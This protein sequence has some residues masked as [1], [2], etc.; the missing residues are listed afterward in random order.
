VAAAA[1]DGRVFGIMA[2][3]VPRIIVITPIQSQLTSGL[4]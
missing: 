1:G 4:M 3:T 2:M